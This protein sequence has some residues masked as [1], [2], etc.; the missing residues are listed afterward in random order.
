MTLGQHGKVY[1]GQPF[2]LADVVAVD[3]STVAE[4]DSLA[5]QLVTLCARD[6]SFGVQ[7]RHAGPLG[8]TLV[9]VACLQAC[10]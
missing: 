4:L 3:S 7:G 5:P 10:D 6:A 9:Y 2:L 8:T 1:R